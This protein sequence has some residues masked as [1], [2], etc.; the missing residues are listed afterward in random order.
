MRVDV[1]DQGQWTLKTG[2]AFY[3]QAGR[4]HR[5]INVSTRPLTQITVAYPPRY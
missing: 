4:K 2:D 5:V 1:A 3:V